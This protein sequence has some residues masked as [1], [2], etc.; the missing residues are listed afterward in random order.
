MT[1]SSPQKSDPAALSNDFV[2][3]W[4]DTGAAVMEAVRAAGSSGWYILGPE[5][6]EFEARLAAHWGLPHA[7]GVASGLDALELSLRALGCKAADKVL[8]TPI[9]A[10]ATTLAIVRIGAIPVFVD[11]DESGLSDLDAAERILDNRPDIRFFVPV[12]LYGQCIDLDKLKALRDKF[13]LNI[14]EDCAQSIGASYAGRP[15]G[16]VGQYAATSFYPTKNLG[17][18]GDGGAVLT[19]SWERA[20]ML[21]VLRDYG[22][23]RKYLHTVVGADRRLDELQAAILWRAYLPKLDEWTRRR[24]Q[25]ADVYRDALSN[26]LCPPLP[27]APRSSS[28]HHLFP[29]LVPPARKAE[30]IA[31]LRARGVQAGEHYPIPIMEQPALSGVAHEMI[32]DCSVA[33]RIC[34]SEVSLPI[35]P[36]LRTKRSRLSSIPV[37]PGADGSPFVNHP[38]L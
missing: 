1:S 29:V 9:S 8:T 15:S 19:A 36:Y 18:L 10:F 14:V 30:F 37:T 17:A 21:R 20:G 26:P 3:Q 24:R 6:R 16:S 32:G 7:I 31:F 28:C 23:E 22:Q 27:A 12:H 35:H 33:R 38:G 5:V 13:S 34:R 11:C 2:R 4:E 25:V